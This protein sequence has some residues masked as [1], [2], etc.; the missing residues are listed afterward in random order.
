MW[1]AYLYG[2][3]M[4][5]SLTPED[6]SWLIILLKIARNIA[7]PKRDNLV[8]TAGYARVIQMM[9]EGSEF[10][11]GKFHPPDLEISDD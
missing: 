1:N 7:T 8:D 9:Q 6:V 11:L 2:R 3:G 5:A 4:Q 10:S